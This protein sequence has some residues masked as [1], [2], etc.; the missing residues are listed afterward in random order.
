MASTN[1]DDYMGVAVETPNALDSMGV[2]VET[3]DAEENDIYDVE[4]EIDYP[5][6]AEVDV[7]RVVYPSWAVDARNVESSYV[8]RMESRVTN[9]L[10]RRLK[11]STL[12]DDDDDSNDTQEE[13][14]RR[15]LIRRRKTRRLIERRK[16]DSEAKKS[17]A[18]PSNPLPLNRRLSNR[19]DFLRFRISS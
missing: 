14:A 8:A 3:S 12:Y 6:Q 9:A 11:N 2:A 16:Q 10:L 17:F 15:D 18:A 4:N 1:A 5:S 13:D 7:A 19:H